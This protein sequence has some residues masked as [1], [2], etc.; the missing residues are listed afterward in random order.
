MAVFQLVIIRHSYA[1]DTIPA[2]GDKF[3]S[4]S[5]LGLEKANELARSLESYMPDFVA[6]STAVRTRETLR[7][8]KEHLKIDSSKIIE[9][10]NLYHGTAD[11]Y[12]SCLE[13]L[14][15]TQRIWIVGHN[16][17]VSYLGQKLCPGFVEGFMPG[18]ALVLESRTGGPDFSGTNW[19]IVELIK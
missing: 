5:Q 8:L 15:D 14:P 12:L 7:I 16:P 1:Q 4:L 10:D 13:E 11:D 17:T 18:D 3:R 2:G 19:K 6:V 9:D